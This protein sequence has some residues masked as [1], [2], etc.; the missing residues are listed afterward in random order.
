MKRNEALEKLQSIK[1][2]GLQ[3]LR[4]LETDPRTAT[5]EAEI[6]KLTAQLRRELE[7]EYARTLPER[8]QKVMSLFELSVYTPTIE[9]MWKETGIRRLKLEGA[10][11]GNWGEVL[12][13]VVY[14]TSKYLTH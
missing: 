5:S 11:D 6:R 7:A 10:I 9:E 8:A 2:Q 4:L 13:A 3:A 14:K 12:E 1:S